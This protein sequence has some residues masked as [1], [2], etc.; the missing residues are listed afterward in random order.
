MVSMIRD[1]TNQSM[2]SNTNCCIQTLRVVLSDID[3]QKRLIERIFSFAMI[4]A[5]IA[6]RDHRLFSKIF[7]MKYCFNV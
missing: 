1:V 7:A 3:Q 4:Y 5:Q 6:K 2:E